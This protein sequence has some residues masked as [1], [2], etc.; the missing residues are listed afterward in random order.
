MIPSL[1]RITQVYSSPITQHHSMF[2]LI[3]FLKSS[4][5]RQILNCPKRKVHIN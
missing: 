1:V 5:S 3:K 2:F 4:D